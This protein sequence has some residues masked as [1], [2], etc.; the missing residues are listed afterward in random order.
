M[1]KQ[2][3]SRKKSRKSDS[4]FTLI[5]L[6]VV[7]A[8]IA[9]IAAILFSVFQKVRENARRASCASNLKLL[10]LAFTQYT[11]DADE[12]FPQW[13]WSHSNQS[14]STNPNDATTFWINAIYPY[15]KSAGDYKCPDDGASDGLTGMRGWFTVD[16]NN[17]ITARGMVPALARAPISY[18]A[19][20][21]LLN[22]NTSLAQDAQPAA[23]LLVAD[24]ALA[25]TGATNDCYPDWQSA[26]A[27]GNSNDPRLHDS[28]V[29]V[30]YPNGVDSIPD[31]FNACSA[32]AEAGWDRYARHSG[33]SNIGFVDGHV[34]WLRSSQITVK[35]YGVTGNVD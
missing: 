6:L 11:Q 15:V 12:N 2:K 34:K 18:G 10:A 5:E 7:I 20:E 21:P 26:A 30:A 17:A 19:N 9:I 23:T 35:L 8:I 3:K 14:G 32:P 28:I 29:R 31:F 27:S 13:K 1:A 4:G 25:L 16:A 33:G 22:S 24:S